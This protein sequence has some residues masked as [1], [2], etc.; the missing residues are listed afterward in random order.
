M[1]IGER[2]TVAERIQTLTHELEVLDAQRRGLVAELARLAGHRVQKGSVTALALGYL[3]QFGGPATTG[4]V[5]DYILLQRPWMNRA[6]VGVAL[7]RA[8]RRNQIVRQGRGWVL[9]EDAGA[10]RPAS[11]VLADAGAGGGP[12]TVSRG[13][14]DE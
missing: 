3:R 8:A 9:P 5:L 6:G 13:E 12:A 2:T 7:Y 10:R 1:A 4:E 14:G 11:H